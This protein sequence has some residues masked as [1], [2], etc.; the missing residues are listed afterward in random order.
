MCNEK[1]KKEHLIEEGKITFNAKLKKCL[2]IKF[3]YFDEDEL[4]DY[5]E[6]W[7]STPS[8]PQVEGFSAV[9]S[10]YENESRRRWLFS[11]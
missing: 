5:E 10:K 7:G 9:V 8:Y 11:L 3:P 2:D 6:H 1:L 4:E